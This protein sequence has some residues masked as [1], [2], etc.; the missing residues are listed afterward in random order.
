MASANQSDAGREVDLGV[1]ILNETLPLRAHNVVRELEDTRRGRRARN[2]RN[3]VVI[4]RRPTDGGQ[5]EVDVLRRAIVAKAAQAGVYAQNR[6]G[7]QSI[8][9]P[10]GSGMTVVGFRAAVGA[11]PKRPRDRG[12]CAACRYR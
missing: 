11:N 10:D 9:V 5:I 2:V 6:A 3:G 1:A 8:G 12:R 7:R 4:L